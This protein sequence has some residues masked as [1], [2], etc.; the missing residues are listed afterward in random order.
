[1]TKIKVVVVKNKLLNKTRKIKL[2]R[3][4]KAQLIIV[5]VGNFT[6]IYLQP[7]HNET[8]ETF[9]FLI[10][11]PYISDELLIEDFFFV[12]K[13]CT[14]LLIRLLLCARESKLVTRIIPQ[15]FHRK[16]TH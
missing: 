5:C 9:H 6:T 7:L 10:I 12:L 3:S 2:S 14:A 4:K 1:M 13:P 8:I 15:N 16:K 11:S